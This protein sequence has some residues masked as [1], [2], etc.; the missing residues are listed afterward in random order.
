V[1]QTPAAAGSFPGFAGLS[2]LAEQ[3]RL[4]AERCARLL[5][6]VESDF[7]IA[8]WISID[9]GQVDGEELPFIVSGGCRASAKY[10]GGGE[11]IAGSITLEG[12]RM[13]LPFYV[14]AGTPSGAMPA[15]GS[16]NF[17][18]EPGRFRTVVTVPARETEHSEASLPASAAGTPGI[19]ADIR[20]SRDSLAQLSIAVRRASDSEVRRHEKRGAQEAPVREA[21]GYHPQSRL[22]QK[23]EL[24]S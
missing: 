17:V 11:G 2:A 1:C 3:A 4:R 19:V 23:F 10:A 24:N 5:V 22:E 16:G 7:D 21:E 15:T 12:F 8:C 6:V 13:S 20:I 18:V 14:Q 9:E